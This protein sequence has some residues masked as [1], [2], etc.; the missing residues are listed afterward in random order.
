[1]SIS[2]TRGTLLPPD[3]KP[4]CNRTPVAKVEVPEATSEPT[5]NTTAASWITWRARSPTSWMQQLPTTASRMW[6]RR[7][8][9][10]RL[11]WPGSI[12]VPV[13]FASATSPSKVASRT[14]A[15]SNPSWTRTLVQSAQTQP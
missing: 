2:A 10:G 6:A 3:S 7:M 14:L 5:R 1:M 4:T 11:T 12:T 13:N 15:V 8:P 9:V